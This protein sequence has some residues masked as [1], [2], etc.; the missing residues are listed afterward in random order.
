[1]PDSVAVGR[2]AASHR[3]SA[4][5]GHSLE[6]H[7]GAPARQLQRVSA[8][9]AVSSWPP[10][11]ACPRERSHHD[12]VGGGCLCRT[13]YTGEDCSKLEPQECNDPRSK[14]EAG[15][16]YDW[17]RVLSRCTGSC[18]T[19]SNRCLCGSRARYPRRHMRMCEFRDVDSIM[20]WLDPGWAHFRILE[21][22]QL[23]RSPNTTPPELERRVGAQKLG[24]LWARRPRTS[25]LSTQD[26][27]WCDREIGRPGRFSC[28]C[29][30]DGGG[31][32][33]DEPV[34]AFCLNQCSGRGRCV[35]GGERRCV[36]VRRVHVL[37][38]AQL[39]SANRLL[40]RLDEA[41]F[42]AQGREG[43]V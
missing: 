12:L 19:L 8:A 9:L 13:G 7:A 31:P 29:Y 38:W 2:S 20:P 15:R 35:R 24:K 43:V 6:L 39:S 22:W 1:M 17:T 41:H 32:T 10:R 26:E 40:E 11:L 37:C 33:C 36:D 30:E 3:R 27:A 23:W 34:L 42:L 18:D 4:Q 28:S 5:L 16:D 14:V 25:A 21:P